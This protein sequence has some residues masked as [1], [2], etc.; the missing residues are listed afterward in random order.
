MEKLKKLLP[1]IIIGIVA[2]LIIVCCFVGEKDLTVSKSSTT[3]DTNQI[4]SNAQT[5]SS[6]ISDEDKKDF[7]NIDID[8]Y[9]EFYDGS[10]EKLVFIGR[11]TCSYCQIAE[12]IVKKINKDYNLNIYYLN[13]DDFVDDD[14]AKFI[15][16]DEF[17]KNGYGTP[18]LFVVSNGKIV[19]KVDGLTD[20]NHYLEF[21]KTNNFIS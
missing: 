5:E 7:E 4:L 1:V 12:P 10:E 14:E 21:L 15:N 19:D 11:P 16:S 8:K 2:I 20:T 6:N 9:L 3:N 13:T 18:M 17:L